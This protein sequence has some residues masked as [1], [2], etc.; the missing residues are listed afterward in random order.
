MNNEP[1]DITGQRQLMVDPRVVDSFGRAM[2]C[3]AQAIKLGRVISLDERLKDRGAIHGTS[4][5]WDESMQRVRL[6]YN[7]RVPEEKI[8]LGAIAL[9]TDGL[10]FEKPQLGLEEFEGSTD[11]N[12]ICV[13]KSMPETDRMLEPYRTDGPVVLN[14]KLDEA[15]W[16]K[17]AA[18]NQDIIL[19]SGSS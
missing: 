7:L 6:Y 3:M 19:R 9:S 13:T 11:N 16:Q 10:H 12:L 18:M 5:L 2:P 1:L 4:A 15:D 8:D 17:A 14:G